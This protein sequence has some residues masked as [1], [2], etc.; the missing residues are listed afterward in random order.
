VPAAGLATICTRFTADAALL[1]QQKQPPVQQLINGHMQWVV[2]LY[3]YKEQQDAADNCRLQ[4]NFAAALSAA[5]AAAQQQLGAV[6]QVR[7]AACGWLLCW[8]IDS[9]DLL[10]MRSLQLYLVL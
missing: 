7:I 4:G 9:R 2:P 10:A 5:F 3:L 8:C 6:L 1:Q